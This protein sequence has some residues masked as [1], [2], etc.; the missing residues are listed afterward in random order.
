[1]IDF[2]SHLLVSVAF[3]NPL[4]KENLQVQFFGG[5]NS[6][7]F[8]TVFDSASFALSDS[9]CLVRLYSCSLQ[10]SNIV[11]ETSLTI[12]KK[13]DQS[14]DGHCCRSGGHRG[15]SRILGLDTTVRVC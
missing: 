15:F 12:L 7:Y 11:A 5:F 3:A 6:C 4:E 1:M 9:T 14:V 10:T 2:A 8:L 13:V